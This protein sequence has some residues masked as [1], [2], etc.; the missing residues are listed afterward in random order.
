MKKTITT[1]IL[2][3][4]VYLSASA[5]PAEEF[6]AKYAIRVWTTG[7]AYASFEEDIKGSIKVGKLADFVILSQDPTK[8]RPDTVKDTNAEETYVGGKLVYEKR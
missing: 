2:S 3:A 8:V 5:V 6:S 7:S 4:L 1:T